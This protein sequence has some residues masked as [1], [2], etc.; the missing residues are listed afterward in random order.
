MTKSLE[1][2]FKAASK[3][4]VVDQKALAKWVIEEL[5]AAKKWERIFAIQ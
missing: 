2:A 4:P 3:L 5:E 1:K